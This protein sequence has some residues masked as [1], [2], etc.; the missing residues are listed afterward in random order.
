M[1]ERAR[2]TDPRSHTNQHLLGRLFEDGFEGLAHGTGHERA[3]GKG[4]VGGTL[5]RFEVALLVTDGMAGR[6]TE[7]RT[8]RN[9]LRQTSI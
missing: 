2:P 6:P 7:R 9:T 1:T 5:H 4:V 3:V 8:D